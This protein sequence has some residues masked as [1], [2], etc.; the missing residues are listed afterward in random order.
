MCDR[1]RDFISL[2]LRS[3]SACS[4]SS[5]YSATTPR[6][7]SSSSRF[8][9]LALGL[10]LLRVRPGFRSA[11]GSA[12]AA[13]PIGSCRLRAAARRHRR[14]SACALSRPPPR[15][16]CAA[17][18]RPRAARASIRPRTGRSGGARCT[19]PMPRPARERLRPFRMASRSAMPGPLVAD[20]DA[21]AAARCDAASSAN[22]TSPPPRVGQGVARDLRDRGGDARLILPVEAEQLGD[23]ARAA[24]APPRRRLGL[25]VERACERACGSLS[26]RSGHQH[27]GVVAAAREVAVQ[28]RGH[29]HRMRA[30]QARDSG[31]ATS[32]CRCRR[33]A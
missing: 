28:H 3:C 10:A 11:R 22:S 21:E 4:S 6:L 7:V 32:S 1:K 31:R 30:Q 26:A 18:A 17:P 14:R 2:A 8:R 12:R 16:A 5:A 9:R 23:A 19:R 13:P 25:P 24:A 29:Q 33:N 27:R 15:A 20:H